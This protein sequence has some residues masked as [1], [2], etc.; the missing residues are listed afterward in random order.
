M[1]IRDRP[2]KAGNDQAD[3][4]IL[5]SSADGAKTFDRIRD[6][7][8]YGEMYMSLLR[9]QDE[10]LLLTFTVRDLN[11][12]LGVRA[13]VGTESDDGFNFEFEV[14]NVTTTLIFSRQISACRRGSI[15][16]DCWIVTTF[17]RCWICSVAIWKKPLRHRRSTDIVSQ[18]YHC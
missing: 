2:I 11:P 1:P 6:F 4:F 7:G 16:R 14:A 15:G 9:L 5:F 3:H 8:D 13:L 12:P 18:Q 17:G 10:R